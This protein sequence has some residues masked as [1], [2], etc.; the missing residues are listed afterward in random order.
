MA[1]SNW[2]DL[3]NWLYIFGVKE[4]LYIDKIGSYYSISCDGIS[5]FPISKRMAKKLIKEFHVVFRD[6]TEENNDD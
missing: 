2:K 6:F 3:C 5:Y 1:Y 4:D